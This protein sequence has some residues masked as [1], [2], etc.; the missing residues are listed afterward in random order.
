IS[1]RRGR[2][3]R[4]RV[5]LHIAAML[6]VVAAI[7]APRLIY[8]HETTG[9]WVLDVR[10]L[11]HVPVNAETDLKWYRPPNQIEVPQY[12]LLPD[13][14]ATAPD[15]TGWFE[16]LREAEESLF[17]VIGYPTWGLAVIWLLVGGRLPWDRKRLL[18]LAAVIL[19]ELAIVGPVKM[20]RRYVVTVAGL[21]QVF[22]GLGAV[23]FA[24][25]LRG[26]RR[27]LGV[28][29]K[30]V[31][32]QLAMLALIAG[33]LGAIS[34]FGTNQG[35]R[36][37]ELRQLGRRIVEEF[38][39]GEVILATSPEA[40]YYADGYHASLERKTPDISPERLRRICEYA[41]VRPI[42][43]RGDAGW[44]TWL[45]GAIEAGDLPDG[46]VV[47]RQTRDDVTAY[48]IDAEKLFAG[49]AGATPR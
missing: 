1:F 32:G 7:W 36:H 44:C 14:A 38:G 10:V 16:K 42:V 28:L 23:A 30:S 26:R 12:L 49:R 34:I 15:K 3:A 2:A 11:P 13:G 5:A 20:D 48:L 47:A 18:I 25:F 24:E 19:A 22:A 45:T 43:I 8:T 37:R 33:A 21:A 41:G 31:W 39:P 29:G 9:H 46:A 27:W 35:T 40:A 17:W 6:A 4:L